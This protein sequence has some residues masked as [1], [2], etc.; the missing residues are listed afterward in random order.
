MRGRYPTPIDYQ[1]LTNPPSIFPS[2]ALSQPPDYQHPFQNA[3]HLSSPTSANSQPAFSPLFAC[4]CVPLQLAAYVF[5]PFRLLRRHSV[6]RNLRFR[7][8]SLAQPNSHNS[9]PS[10]SSLLPFRTALRTL[11]PLFVLSSALQDRSEYTFVAFCSLNCPL[12]PLGVH[13]RYFLSSQPPLGAARSTLSPLFVRSTALR[14]RS[15]YTFASFC[16]RIRPSR[17]LGVRFRHFCQPSPRPKAGR[18]AVRAEPWSAGADRVTRW[19]TQS[20]L[21]SRRKTFSGS[22]GR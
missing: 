21:P 18:Q 10:F 13:F 1:P 8:F 19:T 12:G 15:A 14:G 9:R 22:P 3:P 17:P 5:C 4:K 11:S 2:M 6:T 16:S 20:S 7:R